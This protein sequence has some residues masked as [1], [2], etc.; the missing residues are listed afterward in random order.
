MGSHASKDNEML[1]ASK[2]MGEG[3]L[4]LTYHPVKRVVKAAADPAKLVA[5]T[6]ASP[7]DLVEEAGAASHADEEEVACACP[8]DKKCACPRD[9]KEKERR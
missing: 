8:R 4:K 3:V 1:G 2:D 7:A 5:H 6:V 9:K